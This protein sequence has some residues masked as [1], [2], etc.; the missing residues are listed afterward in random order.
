MKAEFFTL[1]E[2]NSEMFI[3]L[4]KKSKDFCKLDE[5]DQKVL[6][7]T[8]KKSPNSLRSWIDYVASEY[9]TK[10]SIEIDVIKLYDDVKRLM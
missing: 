7:W 6:L 10:K 3:E 8:L 9:N 2:L 4:M 5:V 1:F